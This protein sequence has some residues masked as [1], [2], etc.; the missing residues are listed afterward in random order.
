MNETSSPSPDHVMTLTGVRPEHVSDRP[1]AIRRCLGIAGF[2]MLASVASLQC[3]AADATMPH[4]L[5]DCGDPFKWRFG[6]FDYRTATE[7]QKKIVEIYHFTPEVESL[8]S[9]VSADIGGELEYVLRAFPNHPRALMALIR[10]GQREKSTKPRG[11]G[12][13]VQCFV[14]RAIAFR[15]D[16]INIRQIRGIFYSLHRQYDQAIAD[17][18]AVI[19]EQPDNA[20]AH[21]NLGL[22]YFE[23]GNYDGA[24]A[25][26]KLAKNLG[27]PLDGLKNMLKAK[28]KWSE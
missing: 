27:F 26:A 19:E 2:A 4:S 22:A 6:P 3:A 14:E 10:L 11:A 16:D 21:Y 8:Q 23:K 5:G 13:T 15:P 25:E 1:A 9:G 24:R 12:Y 28:G 18:T 17:F 7:E 20:N